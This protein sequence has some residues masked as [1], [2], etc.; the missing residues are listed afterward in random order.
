[1]SGIMKIVTRDEYEYLPQIHIELLE[2]YNT[3]EQGPWLQN[4]IDKIKTDPDEVWMLEFTPKK[5]FL[6]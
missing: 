6:Y 3:S 2:K 1:M 4:L 5:I